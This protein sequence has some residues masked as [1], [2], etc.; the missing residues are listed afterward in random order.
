MSDDLEHAASRFIPALG[1]AALTR[2]YDPVLRATLREATFKCALVAQAALAPGMRVLDLGAGT[3]TL[4]L[5][6]Q[7]S[8]P[9]AEIVGVDG[10]P[11]VLALARAKATAAGQTV[12]FDRALA[13]A[14]PYDDASFDR[15]VSSL[16]LHHLSPADKRR[17]L[18]EV[19]RILAGGGELHVA[20]WGRPRNAV[21][22]ALFLGVQLLDGFA[23][24]AENVAGMLP[25]LFHEA[26][27]VAVRET[28]AFATVF[29]T[30]ALYRATRPQ[31]SAPLASTS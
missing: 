27:F 12:R 25:E 15:V 24:T 13:Y 14:L 11:E 18:R 16:L 20:D 1:F 10:D 5:M 3:G 31:V 30:L 6:L 7:Q 17:T 9:G 26:G 23:T 28:D 22:R 29:G 4:T 8:A 2:L 19:F 21:M